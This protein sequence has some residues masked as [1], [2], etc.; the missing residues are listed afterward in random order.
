MEYCG[1]CGASLAQICQI[2]K[3]GSP[4]DYRYCGHCGTPFSPIEGTTDHDDL[5]EAAELNAQPAIRSSARSAENGGSPIPSALEGERRQATVLIADVQGST[6]ILEKL[7][8]E[9]WVELMNRVMQIMSDAIYRFGGKVDQFR[10]DGL[11]AFFG[12][13]HAHEDDPER[14]VLAAL[15]LQN[16]VKGVAADLAER[17]EI[18]FQVRVGVN[19]GE[20]IRANIGTAELHTENTPMGGAITLA[21]RLE[22]SAAPGTILVSDTTYRLVETLFKWEFIGE[23][24]I[25]GLSQTVKAYRPLSPIFESEHQHRLQTQGL[26][27]PLIGRDEELSAIEKAVFD[28]RKGVGGIMLV[29]GEA[30]MGKSRLIFEARQ[31]LERGDALHGEK[32]PSVIWLQGRC[33]SYGQSQPYSMWLDLWMRWLGLGRWATPED[34]VNRLR[35]K[36]GQYWGDRLEEYYPYL[37]NFLSLPLGEEDRNRIRD[38]SAEGLKRRF[39]EAIYRLIEIMAQQTPIVLV[40]TEVHWADEASLELL[41]YCLPLCKHEQ[42]LI[43]NVYRS[44]QT[45]RISN[46]NRTIESEYPDSLRTLEL[47]SLTAA[48]C[49]ELIH[50]MVGSQTLTKTVHDQILEKSNGNPYYLTELIRSLVERG[51][52]QRESETGHWQAVDKNIRLDLPDSIKSLLQARIDNLSATERRILQMSA[53]IGPVFWF[54]ILARLAHV[55]GNLGAQLAGL[56]RAQLITERGLVPDLGQEYS[57]TSA[58]IWEAV[59]ESILSADREDLHLRV[60]NVLELTLEKS[61]Q[62]QFHGLL[63]YHYY[64]GGNRNLGL[65]HTLEA[66]QQARRVN[67]NKEAIQAYIQALDLISEPD[68]AK[69]GPDDEALEG[70][71]LETLSALGQVQFGIG[72]VKEAEKNFRKAMTIGRENNLPPKEMA[73]LFYW[74]GEV[75]WWQNSYEEPLRLGEEGLWILGDQSETLEAALMN[76]LI[77]VSSMQLEDHDRFIDFTLRTA[78]FIQRVAYSEELRPA[79]THII[80]LYA[81]TMKNI[82]EARRWLAILSQKAGE[83]HDL[84]ALG[85][86]Y[87]ISADL[88]FREGDISNA[89]PHHQQAIQTFEQL[90][91]SK[92]L[93][94]AWIKLGVSRLQGGE[95]EAAIGCFERAL[96]EAAV[97]ANDADYARGF[98]YKGQA[99]LCQGKWQEAVDLFRNA[100]EKGQQ[101]PYLKEEWAL[102]GVARAFL[103]GGIREKAVEAYREAI[104]RI[105]S[106]RIQSPYHMNEV[107]SGLEL[108]YGSQEEFQT[109]MEDFRRDY[110]MINRS[111]FSQWY[112]TPSERRSIEDEPLFHEQFREIL[113]DE[114]VWQDPLQ[115]CSYSASTGLIIRAANERNLHYVNR[116]APRLVRPEPFQGDFTFQTLCS[117]TSE[118]LP[119]IGGLLVWLGEKYWFCLERGSRGPDEVTL[120]GFMENHDFIYG[121]GLLPGDRTYLRLERKGHWLS[122]AC[123]SDRESWWDVG[124]CELSSGEPLYLGLHANGHI[125]RMVYPGAF[126]AGTAIRFQEFWLWKGFPDD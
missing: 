50:E 74:L 43:I 42:V 119:A 65:T 94:R 10:G 87:D 112:L 99:L 81:N 82:P 126:S 24:E 110:P 20:V 13:Q 111:A 32:D 19:T 66:A 95:I 33:R 70:L 25:R 118:G 41:K 61:L 21:S 108:A 45:S 3:R 48:Q 122:A 53:V 38:L 77:A 123:S 34:A 103:A 75:L 88:F 116:S 47:H 14:A 125:N 67:A 17:Y 54:N 107:F 57:F 27:F 105:P 68:T 18:E 16:E 46:F 15:V 40:F 63:A 31:R 37:A 28:L 80:S 101:V 91:D 78:G 102:I 115:D 93:S 39:F 113:S 26:W 7:G 117:P 8:S 64:H 30:G 86:Y 44:E 23:I 1:M 12:A 29:S 79:Y 9:T 4:Q 114:W 35:E 98:W 106:S 90:G 60:A 49:T 96:K 120:R 36:S 109:F 5:Q 6:T 121:R 104:N 62:S 71:E 52:L 85:E 89:I 84:L 59:Y 58:L 100:A 72:E 51:H 92:Y 69:Q 55:N 56:D 73:K 22:G 11:V 76:Q 2:C 124:G 83:A 97:F